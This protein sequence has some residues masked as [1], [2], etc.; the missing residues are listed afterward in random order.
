MLQALGVVFL[1][2]LVLGAAFPVNGAFNLAILFF[3]SCAAI[4][5]GLIIR[6]IRRHW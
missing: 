2:L 1:V 3:G 5:I 6:S 4:I